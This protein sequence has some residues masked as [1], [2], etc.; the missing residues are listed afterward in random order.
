MNEESSVKIGYD[1]K[2]KRLKKGG[3]NEKS[4]YLIG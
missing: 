4:G 2:K 3:V 1:K